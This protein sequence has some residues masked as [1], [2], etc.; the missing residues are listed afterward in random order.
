VLVGT[1]VEHARRAGCAHTCARDGSCSVFPITASPFHWEARERS[2][3]S[4]Q[5]GRTTQHHAATFGVD[6][7]SGH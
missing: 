3:G 6:A 2:P 4:L 7:V 5:V 1:L